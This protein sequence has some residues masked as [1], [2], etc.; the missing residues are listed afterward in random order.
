MSLLVLYVYYVFLNKYLHIYLS[1]YLC[2]YVRTASPISKLAGSI[3]R[4]RSAW[5]AS[6]RRFYLSDTRLFPRATAPAWRSSRRVAL[7]FRSA[8]HSTQINF[9][10]VSIV[11]V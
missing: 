9:E 4:L 7:S 2:M 5:F 1:M 10:L 8:S 11:M 3:C 6:P